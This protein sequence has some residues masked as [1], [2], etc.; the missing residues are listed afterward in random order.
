MAVTTVAQFAEQLKRPT[1]ALIEQLASAG[2]PKQSPDDALT[3]ADKE[4]LLEYLRNAHGTAAGGERKNITITRKSTTEIKQADSSGRNRTIQVD[5]FDGRDNIFTGRTVYMV[6]QND[7]IVGASV[8]DGMRRLVLETTITVGASGEPLS[9]SI[10]RYDANTR[11]VLGSDSIS[12]ASKAV[13]YL[14]T[15]LLGYDLRSS[16]QVR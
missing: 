7:R 2:V 15:N 14:N 12:E 3:D 1:A 9:V 6:D 11:V 5:R 10:T 8:Y 16:L 13:T 4:R